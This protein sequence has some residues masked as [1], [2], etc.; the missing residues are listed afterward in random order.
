MGE[1]QILRSCNGAFI[2]HKARTSLTEILA[3]GPEVE[4]CLTELLGVDNVFLA[5]DQGRAERG[6]EFGSFSPRRAALHWGSGQRPVGRHAAIQYGHRIMAKHLA[7][8]I[9]T[10]RAGHLNGG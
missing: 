3:F 10:R 9:N 8:P 6:L 1:R 7:G 5:G 2:L 4:Q